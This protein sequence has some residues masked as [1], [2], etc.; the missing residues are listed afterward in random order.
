[1]II[2][3]MNFFIEVKEMFINPDDVQIRDIL[4]KAR[5]IA[6]VG[7]SENREKDSHR[8]AEYLA[9][10]GYTVIP[11]NPGAREILGRQAYPGLSSVPVE[12]DIVD[13]FRRSEHLAGVVEE[14]LGVKAGCIWAQEGVTDEG[15]AVGAARQG[16]PVVMDR[17]IMKEHRRLIGDAGK[18]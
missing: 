13:V 8:V 3:F 15:A 18:K 1:M 11:V 10:N 2:W 9:R 5:N 6:V 17:C 12:V 4:K 7:L 16:V 14:S